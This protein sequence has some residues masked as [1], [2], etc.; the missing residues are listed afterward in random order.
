MNEELVTGPI[1]GVKEKSFYNIYIE[2][3]INIERGLFYI[4]LILVF[5]SILTQK[6]ELQN[7][8]TIYRNANKYIN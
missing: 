8:L 4:D 6:C 7:N 2:P 1:L 5:I 3:H